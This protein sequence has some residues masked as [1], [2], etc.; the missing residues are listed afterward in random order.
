[1]KILYRVYSG[2]VNS[3][4]AL[5]FKYNFSNTKDITLKVSKRGYRVEV[6][7]TVMKEADQ[8]LQDMLFKDALRKVSRIQLIKYGEIFK[9]SVYAEIKG[10]KSCIYNLDAEG[11][12]ELIYSMCGDKLKRRFADHWEIDSLQRVVSITKTKAGRMDAALDAA[13]MAKSKI[14]ETERF[15]YLWMAMN[16]MYGYA[17][18]VAVKE[19][20][21]KNEQNWIGKEY[22]QLKFFAMLNGYAYRTADK[23]QE[24][25][26]IKQ[27]ELLIGKIE[28]GN[29]REIIK[30]VKENNDNEFVRGVVAIFDEAGISSDKMH[31]YAALLLYA[32]YSFRCKYFH[33]ERVM[34]LICFENEHPIPVLRFL[35]ILIED[36][37][38]EN[39][40][41]WFSKECYDGE[42]YPRITEI[43]RN[44]KC[45]KNKRLVSCVFDGEDI[46]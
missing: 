5:T 31:P 29:E 23:K 14:Y 32:S 37:I 39:L 12:N 45:D 35:N 6:Y 44:C 16:G 18:E 27:L 13:L 7:R 30:S 20:S 17:A 36:Y 11:Q 15:I 9:G 41:K 8:L 4:T 2:D 26:V 3:R 43:A 42:I 24:P 46:A 21:S 28:K 25:D 19:M 22:G 10:K 38:D 40:Y 34:P 1:M 33:A